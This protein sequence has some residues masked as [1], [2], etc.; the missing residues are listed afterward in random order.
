MCIDSVIFD[1]EAHLVWLD[2]EIP[3]LQEK[4]KQLEDERHL[5]RDKAVLAPLRRIP[6]V[7]GEI[8]SCTSPSIAE[9][10]N[11]GRINMAQSPWLLT[12][13]SDRGRAV[14][15]SIPSLWSRVI[16]D[17]SEDIIPGLSIYYSLPLV[18]AH[19][20]HAQKLKLHFYD[21]EH[22][23]SRPQI[24]MFRLLLRYSSSPLGRT[25]SRIS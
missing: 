20:Q 15:L 17:Y 6:E 23:D 25:R 24:Q 8:F 9:A 13:T 5:T 11:A 14:S 16:I 18:E 21:S 10:L 12:Q 1:T 19:I 4:L 3:K 7:L 2:D 22:A